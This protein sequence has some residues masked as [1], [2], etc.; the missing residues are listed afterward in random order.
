MGE[1]RNSNNSKTGL[2]PPNKVKI[3]MASPY[4]QQQ[5]SLSNVLCQAHDTL[6]TSTNTPMKYHTM[7]LTGTFQQNYH[8][9]TNHMNKTFECPKPQ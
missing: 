8:N 6:Y 7:P 3:N 4:H 2:T 5:Q 1:R 9:P